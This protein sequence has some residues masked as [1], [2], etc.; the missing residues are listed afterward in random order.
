MQLMR[1]A[2]CPSSAACPAPATRCVAR[3]LG[4]GVA[5]SELRVGVAPRSAHYLRPPGTRDEVHRPGGL[6]QLACCCSTLLERLCVCVNRAPLSTAVLSSP[7]PAAEHSVL[8]TRTTIL[9][10]P[11]H[12]LCVQ[13]TLPAGSGDGLGGCAPRQAAPR[14]HLHR[15]IWW[16][17]RLLLLLLLLPLL[18]VL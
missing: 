15:H 9:S 5:R 13:P 8:C 12:F 10:S 6:W 3:L 18:R 16:V 7:V 14:A 17:L 4:F 2:M 11:V 1:A